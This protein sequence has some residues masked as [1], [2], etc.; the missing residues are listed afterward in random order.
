MKDSKNTIRSRRFNSSKNANN[1]AKAV[2]GTVKDLRN[3][4][5]RKSNYKVKY[6]KGDAQNRKDLN[7]NYGTNI[8]ED[9]FEC[10]SE[11]DTS[12]DSDNWGSNCNG[13]DIPDYIEEGTAHFDE[14]GNYAG[15][16]MVDQSEH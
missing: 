16:T 9:I 12:N 13:S 1:F 3:N 6:T 15:G 8:D 5:G 2:N 7:S 4:S 11:E 10:Q 14:D